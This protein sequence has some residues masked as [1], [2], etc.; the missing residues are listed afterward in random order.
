MNNLFKVSL[1]QSAQIEHNKEQTTELIISSE[2]PHIHGEFLL[3]YD[4]IFSFFG[5]NISPVNRLIYI[6]QAVSDIQFSD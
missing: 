1:L 3:D 6:L 2:Y 5:C 4:C